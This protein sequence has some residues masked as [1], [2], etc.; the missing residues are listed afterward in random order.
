MDAA[1]LQ[2]IN[3]GMLLYH[4]N[5]AIGSAISDGRT[6][7]LINGGRGWKDFFAA[8]YAGMQTSDLDNL[9]NLRVKAEQQ[10]VDYGLSLSE[11]IRRGNMSSPY[12][13]TKINIFLKG[14]NAYRGVSAW[15]RDHSICDW[16]YTDPRVATST[17][18]F[19][20]LGKVPDFVAK[21][22]HR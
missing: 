13:Q 16:S 7:S 11:S 9:I 12:E 4:G 18:L 5:A 2:A 8:Y 15:C 17:H 14:A 19:A 1:V 21:T 22:I 6:Y 10:G 3:D 20:A